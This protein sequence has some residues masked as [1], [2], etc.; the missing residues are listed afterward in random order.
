MQCYNMFYYVTEQ[1]NVCYTY[2]AKTQKSK[3]TWG[4]KAGEGAGEVTTK[5]KALPV[6]FTDDLTAG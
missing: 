2:V 6:L 5:F 3:N 4:F 1:V